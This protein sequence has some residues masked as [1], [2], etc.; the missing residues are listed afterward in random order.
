MC[1]LAATE[2]STRLVPQHRLFD[3]MLW[4]KPDSAYSLVVSVIVL[5]LLVRLLAYTAAIVGQTSAANLQIATTF[6][7]AQRTILMRSWRTVVSP[8]TVCQG[9]WAR[10]PTSSLAILA[11]ATP[12]PARVGDEFSSAEP[13]LEPQAR[14][15]VTK[16]LART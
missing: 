7:T 1:P 14:I 5:S 13:S 10:G 3:V 16:Y 9:L 15:Q 8:N 6:I 4:P 11:M 12:I 2:I